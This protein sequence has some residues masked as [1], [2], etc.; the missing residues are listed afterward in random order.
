MHLR[1]REIRHRYVDTAKFISEQMDYEEIYAFSV[2]LDR[3]YTSAFSFM[4]GLYPPGTPTKL[5][6]N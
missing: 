2:D 3:A 5:W 4:T 6:Q 1:G